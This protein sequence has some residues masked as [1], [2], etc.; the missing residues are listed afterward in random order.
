MSSLS[1]LLPLLDRSLH[2]NG[3]G[4]QF[5]ATTRLLG[6][7][8]ELDSVAVLQLLSALEQQFAIR[9]ADDEVSAELFATV[10]SLCDFIDQKTL[11]RNLSGDTHLP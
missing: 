8:P 6:A 2:L 1:T 9:I 11:N 7:L 4:L 5:D 10:G 3:R